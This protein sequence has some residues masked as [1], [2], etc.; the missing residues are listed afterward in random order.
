[1][2]WIRFCFVR[3][4]IDL[5]G[6]LSSLK[7]WSR[8]MYSCLRESSL[9]CLYVLWYLPSTSMYVLYVGRKKSRKYS[10]LLAMIGFCFS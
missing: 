1:M 7:L 10:L 8:D 6:I 3:L 5:L 4:V 9:D 2:S